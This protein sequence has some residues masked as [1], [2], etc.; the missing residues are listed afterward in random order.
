MIPLPDLTRALLRYREPDLGRAIFEVCVT[1]LPMAILWLL[2][3][4]SLD[5]GYWL[6]LLLAVTERRH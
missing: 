3:W 6:T 2:M 4:L 1:L 5:V